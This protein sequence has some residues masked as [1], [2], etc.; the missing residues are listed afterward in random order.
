MITAIR[1]ASWLLAVLL[2]VVPAL[3][4]LA[5]E[6]KPQVRIVSFGL[7]GD[8]DVFESEAK[9]AAQIAAGRF[10][11]AAAAIR[12]NS[13][14]RED[15][16]AETLAATLQ[17]TGMGMD[18]DHDIL[19]V[20]LTSHG[21]RAGIAVKTPSREAIL[22]PLDLV[23]M[24]EATHVRHRIV[25]ISA[26]FSGV[27]IPPLADPDTLVITA[28]D[29]EHT[30]FGCRNGNA[31]TFFGDA[32]FNMAL[33]R[34]GNLR[35]AFA[36]ASAAIRKREI[37][38]H[39]EPSNPQMAGGENVERILA[40]GQ[41]GP[42]LDARY[43]PAFVARGSGYVDRGDFDHAIAA[44]NEAI[45]LDPTYARAYAGRGLADRAK[46]DLEHAMAD[47]NQALTL[48][49]KLAEAYNVRG[50][51]HISKG[52]K[53]EAITDYSEAIRLDPRHFIVYTNRAIAFGAKGDNDH[54][55]AD[56][57]EALK[58]EPR[59]YF[60]Y[61]QRGITYGA[62]GDNSRAIADFN[63]AIKLNP[64]FAD[65]F[66]KRGLAYRAKGDTARAD[67]DLKEAARLKAFGAHP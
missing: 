11:G 35:D 18:A 55:I 51:T 14:T 39:F 3:P 52:E 21:S 65:A 45:R 59:F 10:G 62:K 61:Y 27:F 20:I 9:G 64:K 5:A 13:K 36:Q 47:S 17:A 63:Q 54:A 41:D 26:C 56:Y 60:A 37:Q 33:R 42:R 15:A 7:F 58:L 49:P 31:W 38:N 48:D 25:V 23:I 40:G 32:F 53:E 50:M 30:S 57:S 16:T 29:A 46:G 22:S 2:V 66:D 44:Y 1:T 4:A 19:L 67:A 28:A 6:S 12:F 34:T 8:Q 43:A 24:L